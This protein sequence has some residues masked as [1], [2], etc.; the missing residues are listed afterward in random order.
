MVGK[1]KKL[2]L[3]AIC[4]LRTARIL[5]I[6]ELP[7]VPAPGGNIEVREK[8][9]VFPQRRKMAVWCYFNYGHRGNI[10]G[11]KKWC[12]VIIC[13]ARSQIWYTCSTGTLPAWNYDS[14][15]V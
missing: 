5:E 12:C 14:L 4:F 6:T 10:K 7:I 1:T 9:P 2:L 15:G 11:N 13:P 3:L 8:F